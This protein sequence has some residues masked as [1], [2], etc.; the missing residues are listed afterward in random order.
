[1]QVQ[2]LLC[3]AA[4]IREGLIHILGGGV[5][6]VWRGPFPA[7]LGID[8]AMVFTLH[9]TELGEKHRLKVVVQ[10]TDGAQVANLDAEF[11]VG[12]AHPVIEVEPP[13]KPEARVPGESS[14]VPVV[15]PLREV[16]LPGPGSYSIEVLVDGQH[17]QSLFFLAAAPKTG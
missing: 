5:T 7:R 3:D 15:V 12:P 8:L 2:A 1:V 13:E 6:R 16:P 10:S 14:V 4:T 11:E 17:I 9:P